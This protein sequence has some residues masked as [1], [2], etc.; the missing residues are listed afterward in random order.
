MEK[1]KT[2]PFYAQTAPPQ[3]K[4]FRWSNGKMP[5]S[6]DPAMAAA[7]PETDFARALYEGLTDTNSKT[8]EA[9]PALAEKWTASEDKKIWTFY[10]RKDAKWSNGETIT[11]DDFVRSW[12][13][14]AALRERVPYRR[15]F[16][17]ISGMRPPTVETPTGVI[18][19]TDV[20]LLSKTPS[21]P[22][23]AAPKN[24]SNSNAPA[25]KE[26]KK[27]AP[28]ESP[29]P[30]PE[31]PKP[32]KQTKPKPPPPPKFGVEALDDF[33]LR[34]TLLAPDADFPS[35]V[36]HPVFRPV[37]DDDEQFKSGELDADLVTSGAFRIAA[38]GADRIVLDRAETYWAKD[39]VELER[40]SFIVKENAE[41]ALEAYRSGEIDAVTN[42]DFEPLA[43]KLLSPYDDFKRK[44][45][46][47]LN[48]YEINRRKKPFDDRRVREALA[49]SIERGR[50]SEVEME[51]STKPALNFLPFD[52]EH[53]Q[54]IVEDRER[55]KELL[56]EAGFP[57]GDD[58]PVVR[59]VVNRNDVQQRIAKAVVKMW[60]Q[61]L[62]IDTVII[63]KE[64]SEIEAIRQ[65]GDYDILRRGVVLP[66]ADESAALSAIFAPPAKPPVEPVAA[67]PVADPNKPAPEK[68]AEE[69]NAEPK[70]K[71]EAPAASEIP[72]P[73][74][75]TEAIELPLILTED[76]AIAEIPAIPLYFPTSYSLV[77]P[78]IQGFEINTLD[79]PSLKD[80]K[81]DNNWQPKKPNGES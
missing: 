71:E 18:P 35:L 5:R 19:G 7:P 28:N 42:M 65:A 39:R 70:K 81:I 80:V 79:A 22:N 6:F 49:I 52:E 57:D 9:V 73:A 29:S 62:N 27:A 45:H 2:E 17:N 69:S 36:A 75:P 12:K 1:P 60:K 58:F 4:E 31:S 61:V 47:A 74:E 3:K 72:A 46:S 40:V 59:L 13:R 26:E 56:E 48:F 10:L 34:V 67:A 23:A 51:D 64:S 15:L 66:T 50:L 77:K 68:P 33:V 76:E 14:L 37:Y 30:K 43:L 54:K 24:L 63:V 25:A 44:T 11:T 32:E 78:Y 8:L 55:A 20:D 16:E 38:I 21:A 41:K 53:S